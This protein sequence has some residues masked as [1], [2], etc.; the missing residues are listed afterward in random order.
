MVAQL[1]AWLI[2]KLHKAGSVVRVRAIHSVRLPLP[3]RSL[4]VLPTAAALSSCQILVRTDRSIEDERQILVLRVGCRGHYVSTSHQAVP[5]IGFYVLYGLIGRV[6]EK[7]LLPLARPR[8]QEPG[9]YV[10][11]LKSSGKC[12]CA[13]IETKRIS[14]KSPF[15]VRDYP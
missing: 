11:Y 15:S 7:W 12:E 8:A 6:A 3:Q 10:C 13:Q 9:K 14:P 4:T 1:V 2:G 5:V